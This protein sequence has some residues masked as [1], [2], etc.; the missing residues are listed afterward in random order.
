MERNPVGWF[1]VP[2]QDLE[3]AIAFYEKVFDFKLN[4]QTLG[5]LEMAW[6]PM[7]DG[8]P[9]ST[10]TLV[11]HEMYKPSQEGVLVY[12]TAHSGDLTNELNRVEGAGGTILQPKKQI[13]EEYGYMAL[14]LDSEGN[15]L[16]L[17]SVA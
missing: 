14:I 7:L 3:R 2:V 9:G 12:F 1:E 15:R 16:A 8:K 6:F 10:G 4:K 5:P 11:K 13:S 17:H